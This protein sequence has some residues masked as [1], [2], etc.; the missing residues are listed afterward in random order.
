MPAKFGQ[1]IY[2]AQAIR[3]DPT[4]IADDDYGLADHNQLR[5]AGHRPNSLTIV[6]SHIPGQPYSER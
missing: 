5:A 3:S 2:I 6:G 4:D 1:F